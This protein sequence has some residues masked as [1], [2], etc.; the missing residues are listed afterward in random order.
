MAT[1]SEMV[2]S[3]EKLSS[4]LT[5]QKAIMNS[6]D[7]DTLLSNQARQ[8][9]TK[10]KCIGKL[11]VSEAQRMSEIINAGP[12][13]QGD[14]E[15]MATALAN[16]VGTDEPKRSRRP[17]QVLKGFINYLTPKELEHIKNA[18]THNA[19]KVQTLVG[20]C[21]AIGLH[22]PSETTVSHVIGTGIAAGIKA[23]GPDD[24]F[25]LVKEF[26]TQLKARV[27]HGAPPV[28]FIQS[29]PHLPKDLPELT[30]QNA[31]GEGED[32]PGSVDVNT[33]L[34]MPVACRKS[35]KA[36]TPA[37]GGSKS[38]VDDASQIMQ[39]CMQ[40]MMA[41]M[42]AGNSGSAGLAG[43]Q[44]FGNK[45]KQKALENVDSQQENGCQPGVLMLGDKDDSQ[46]TADTE[47]GNVPPGVSKKPSVIF[48]LPQNDALPSAETP[49]AVFDTL[50]EAH[51]KRVDE[52]KQC[53][54]K[55]KP[56]A[57]GK[58]KGK[59]KAKASMKK[60]AASCSKGAVKKDHQTKLPSPPKSGEGTLLYKGGKIHRS[61][62]LSAW[63]VFVRSSDRCDKKIA[64][65]GDEVASFKRALALIEEGK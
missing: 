60:P 13:N 38:S 4:F 41:F 5:Q 18:E 36:L 45:R 31:Y 8:V 54:P 46:T 33:G 30:Y 11:D 50:N 65:K 23:V 1:D 26:K 47:K 21:L 17:N 44:V 10:I 51:Q 64:W 6:N 42:S 29:F 2:K 59:A 20:R 34:G 22:L 19:V 24:R 3:L 40:Y 49:Q 48:D 7:M 62:R 28:E 53:K 61:D 57:K 55:A 9:A 15:L 52:N 27:K 37:S 35:N 43:L 32:A 14:Q 12:W 58:A 39:Q 16:A 56:K 63:R 25:Q